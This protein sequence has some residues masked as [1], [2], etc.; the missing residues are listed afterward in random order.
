MVIIRYDVDIKKGVPHSTDPERRFEF[1]GDG[2]MGWNPI[3]P[4]SLARNAVAV[5]IREQFTAEPSSGITSSFH[6]NKNIA[7]R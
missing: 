3:L 6:V 2:C 7:T 5:R 1:H 4:L